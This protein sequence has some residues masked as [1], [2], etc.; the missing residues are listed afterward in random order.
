MFTIF[1]DS[2]YR[3]WDQDETDTEDE[4]EEMYNYNQGPTMTK[5]SELLLLRDNEK[6][7]L[8][9]KF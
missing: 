3:K 5:A 6:S 9:E 1:L 8:L 4:D 2:Y 7:R